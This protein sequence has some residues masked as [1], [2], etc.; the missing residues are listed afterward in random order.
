MWKKGFAYFEIVDH[1]SQVIVGQ[2][3]INALGKW[4]IATVYGGKDAQTRRSLWNKLED[5]MCGDEPCIIGGDFNCIL[6]K[7][8]K[9]GGKRFHLSNRSKDMKKFMINNDF[10]DIGFVGPSY[11]WCNNKEG[12]SRIWERFDRCLLNSMALHNIPMAKV[13]HLPRVASDHALISINLVDHQKHNSGLLRFE[14]TWK[15]YPATWNIIL[16][17]WARMDFGSCAE[18]LQR[19]LRS[20]KAL[21]YWNK[22]KCRELNSLREE[23]RKDILLLQIEEANEGGLMEDKLNLLRNKVHILNVTLSRLSTWWNQ[24]SKIRWQQVG[25]L[26]SNFFHQYALAK[27][28]GNMIWQIKDDNGTVVEDLEQIEMVFYRFFQKKWSARTCMLSG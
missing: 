21:Y 12:N 7:E 25:D 26:N 14:D 16:K 10:H 18:I 23:L 19:K 11:T 27:K 17:A 4:N 24:R 2:L 6:S 1:S 3:N 22:N 9:R 28:N 8:D 5:R 20:I 15:S 13:H